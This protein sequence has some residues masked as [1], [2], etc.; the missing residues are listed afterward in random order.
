MIKYFIDSIKPTGIWVDDPRFIEEVIKREEYRFLFNYDTVV[1]LG[2]NIGA[3]SFY[4]YSYAKKIYAVEPNPKAIVCLKRTI[5]DNYLDKIIPCE[6]AITSSIGDRFLSII[7][8]DLCYGSSRIDDKAGI[9]V[10]GITIEELMRLYSIEYI[11][12]LKVDIEYSEK[13]LFESQAFKNVSNR[14]GTIIGEYHDQRILES[15]AKNMNEA[16]FRFTSLK[17]KFIARK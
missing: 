8:G 12:L 17:P 15:I 10:K 11:D 5:E 1:D 4:I 13:E 9:I 6:Y 3:F 7:D 16:G 2:A 14:I